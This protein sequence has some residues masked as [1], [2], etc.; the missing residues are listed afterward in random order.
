M[1]KVTR[2][3]MEAY[4]RALAAASETSGSEVAASVRRVMD[5][6][7]GADVA[8]VREAA[9]QAVANSVKRYGNAASALAAELFDEVMEA[10]GIEAPR[11]EAWDGPDADAISQGVRYQ[12]GKLASGDADGFL[13]GVS[14]LASYHTR[15]AASSTVAR[16][17]SRAGRGVRYARVPT[18]ANPCPYCLMLASRGFVYRNEQTAG[19][20]S[21][22]HCTCVLVPGING[23]TNVAGYDP[24]ELFRRWRDGGSST[25]ARD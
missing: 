1:A 16:N 5:A 15:R 9:V 6:L 4:A 11:A 22:R 17:V 7:P 2:R 21:H 19:A 25:E 12:A 20:G 10:E 18:R 23:K 8:T 3:A 24:D 13:D 14:E